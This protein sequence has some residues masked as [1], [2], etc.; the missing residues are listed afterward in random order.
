MVA[1]SLAKKKKRSSKALSAPVK[2]D[3]ETNDIDLLAD[4]YWP[5]PDEHPWT[6]SASV[7]VD[8][9]TGEN[10][11]AED[12]MEKVEH[13]AE[14]NSMTLEAMITG[15]QDHSG[16]TID[17]FLETYYEKYEEQYSAE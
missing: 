8:P 16:N 1:P 11:N 10:L 2:D 13:F 7:G 4:E 9:R 15:I 5:F 17:N 3:K 12:I 14:M 6:R